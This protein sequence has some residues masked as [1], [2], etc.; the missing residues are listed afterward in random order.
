MM[1]I[2]ST[3]FSHTDYMVDTQTVSH[4]NFFTRSNYLKSKA[5]AKSVSENVAYGYSSAESVVGAWLRSESH[6][7]NIEGDFTYFDVSA[8]K[9]INDKWYFTNI[10]IKK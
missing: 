10:F 9:D 3:A 2:K 8:E 5:G 6:K 7:N 4:A 1:I